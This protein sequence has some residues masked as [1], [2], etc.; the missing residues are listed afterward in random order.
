MQHPAIGHDHVK[1]PVTFR[2]MRNRS[3]N[4]AY[5]GGIQQR[6]GSYSRSGT[7]ARAI[8]GRGKY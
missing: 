6:G 7:P 2:E 1:R 3:L 5:V 8:Q 4:Y